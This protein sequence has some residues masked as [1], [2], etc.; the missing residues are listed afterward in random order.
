MVASKATGL[1]T[2]RTATTARMVGAATKTPSKIP[3]EEHKT[4]SKEAL[5]RSNR[6]VTT[7]VAVKSILLK[8]KMVNRKHPYRKSEQMIH[9]WRAMIRTTSATTVTIMHHVVI[10]NNRTNRQ[11]TSLVL[12][13]KAV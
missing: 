1:T 10:T 5:L 3:N 9:Q 12:I 2:Q 11:V 4:K 6:G 13:A 7:P 8:K